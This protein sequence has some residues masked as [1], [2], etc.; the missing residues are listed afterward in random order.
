MEWM[1]IVKS[2]T[3][4]SVSGVVQIDSKVCSQSLLGPLSS[5]CHHTNSVNHDYFDQLV[6]TSCA[7]RTNVQSTKYKEQSVSIKER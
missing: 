1:S 4:Y 7:H 6:E 3:H 5:A 2:I